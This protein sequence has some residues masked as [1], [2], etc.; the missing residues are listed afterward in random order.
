VLVTPGS[1]LVTLAPFPRIDPEG[2]SVTV[3]PKGRGRASREDVSGQRDL[4]LTVRFLC[5]L[6]ILAALAY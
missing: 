1:L 2:S 6:A 5:E 3:A 4:T